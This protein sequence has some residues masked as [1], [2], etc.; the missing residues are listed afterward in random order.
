MFPGQRRL[1]YQ[2]LSDSF[3]QI[4]V[5]PG[6]LFFEG[7][8]E[9]I[10]SRLDRRLNSKPRLLEIEDA[11]SYMGMTAHALRHKAGIEIPVVRIDNK[12]RFDRYDL[13]RY[14]DRAKREGI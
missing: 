3:P 6:N 2:F 14:I 7:L 4:E 9:A 1:T 5:N 8:A 10:V 13:D 11:A 12:L